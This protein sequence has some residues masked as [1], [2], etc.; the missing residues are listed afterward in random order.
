MLNLNSCECRCANTEHA[1]KRR[2]CMNNGTV[3]YIGVDVS[4]ASLRFDAGSFF[5]GD[6]KNRPPAVRRALAALAGKL[7]AGSSPHVCFESTGRYGRNL[8]AACG[9]AG[10]PASTLNPYKV[11][12]YARSM[13]VAAKTDPVDARMIRL[14]AE[15]RRPRPDASPREGGE[16]S[17]ELAGLRALLG[18]QLT[19]LLG[20]LEGAGAASVRKTARAQVKA[21]GR[22]IAAVDARLGELRDADE[23]TAGVCA[24]LVKISGV[25]ELTAMLV[26]ALVPE[27]GTLGRRRSASLAGLAPHPDDSGTIRAPRHICGGRFN[28]RRVLYMASLSAAHFNADLKPVY[29]R[30]VGA[31]KPKKVALVCVMRKLFAHM[32]NVAARWLRERADA[33]RQPAPA[34]P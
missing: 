9:A 24:E 22:R 19:A 20:F 33:G 29:E 16:E 25:G 7:P 17:R 1:D 32:D 13:S 12:M 2:V 14:F 8:S 34:T 23:D 18:K 26:C 10:I 4:K 6:V 5:T 30:L 21:L 28:V 3:V 15:H 11:R 27:L 31:G